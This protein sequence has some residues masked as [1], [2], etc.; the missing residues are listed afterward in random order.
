MDTAQKTAIPYNPLDT[1]AKQKKIRQR[2][3]DILTPELRDECPDLAILVLSLDEY[4]VMM[5]ALKKEAERKRKH[6]NRIQSLTLNVV[7]LPS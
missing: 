3:D 2:I 7:R 4:E 1:H 5:E 6:K